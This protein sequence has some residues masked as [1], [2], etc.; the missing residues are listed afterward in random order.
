MVQGYRNL[1]GTLH[2][3]LMLTTHHNAVHTSKEIIHDTCIDKEDDIQEL[4]EK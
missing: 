3:L 2:V 1:I 4:E